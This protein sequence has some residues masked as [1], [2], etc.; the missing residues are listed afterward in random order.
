M[1]LKKIVGA[2]SVLSLLMFSDIGAMRAAV[3]QNSK[4]GAVKGLAADASKKPLKDYNDEDK[5]REWDFLVDQLSF[6]RTKTLELFDEVD[7]LKS[8]VEKS[9]YILALSEA[10][11]FNNSDTDPQYLD[12]V[13]MKD[14]HFELTSSKR[15]LSI[16]GNAVMKG[17]IVDNAGEVV[18][19]GIFV[20]DALHSSENLIRLYTSSLQRSWLELSLDFDEDAAVEIKKDEEYITES[21]GVFAC[22]FQTYKGNPELLRINDKSLY[23]F[24]RDENNFKDNK[25]HIVKYL[26]DTGNLM[27]GVLKEG[28]KIKHGYNEDGIE[29]G[30]IP[31]VD[32]DDKGEK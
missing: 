21:C 9:K 11:F 15:E 14:K 25:R 18:K 26:G 27:L 17:N 8:V 23:D 20:E 22:D 24:C 13:F 28:T 10:Y 19:E 6:Y 12:P 16:N 1:T 30:F 32:K 3:N 29:I 7:T 5:V 4:E 2:C 31:L